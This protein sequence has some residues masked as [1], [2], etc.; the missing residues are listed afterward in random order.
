MIRHKFNSV[1]TSI[2]DIKFSSKKEAK[3]YVE[4]KHLKEIGDV[5]F[6]LRQVR[7]DLPAGIKYV[8]DFLVFWA[9]GD[10]TVEDVKGLKLPMYVL[11]KKQIETLYPFKIT[12]I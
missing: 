11:K 2:D 5:L 4:L 12:E 10:V 8:C 3:R 9:S 1:K 7:F 6:F